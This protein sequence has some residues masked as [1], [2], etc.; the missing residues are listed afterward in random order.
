MKMKMG[1]YVSPTFVGKSL[2]VY[3]AAFWCLK[4]DEMKKYTFSF[5]L[6]KQ[7][8]RRLEKLAREL[9]RSRS[10]LLCWLVNMMYF[11]LGLATPEEDGVPSPSEREELLSQ[12]ENILLEMRG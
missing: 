10:N 12:L 11:R 3:G 5:R 4:G 1:M 7:T 9:Q 8:S 2:F 6:D